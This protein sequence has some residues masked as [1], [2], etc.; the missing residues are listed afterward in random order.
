MVDKWLVFKELLSFIPD[1]NIL[2]T[3][4][5]MCILCD[6]LL[7]LHNGELHNL[8]S[9]PDIIRQMKLR[10]MSLAGNVARMGEKRKVYRVLAGNPEGKRPL[11]KP[12]PRWEDGIRMDLRKIGCGL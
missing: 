12:R 5:S 11:G 10:K 4:T 2:I 3:F 7:K 1:F 8:Y 6:S 9:S